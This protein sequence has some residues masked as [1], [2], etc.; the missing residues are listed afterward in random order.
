[1]MASNDDH[2]VGNV[3]QEGRSVN[4][5]PSPFL[6]VTCICQGE[7]GM[8]EQDELVDHLQDHRHH[9]NRCEGR[10]CERRGEKGR[11]GRK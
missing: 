5:F 3:I 1:M 11:V 6:K 4:P 9:H 7:P 8:S 2:V 10:K